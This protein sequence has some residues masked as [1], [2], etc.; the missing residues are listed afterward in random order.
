MTSS[1]RPVTD[2]RSQWAAGEKILPLVYGELRRIAR[3]SMNRQGPAHTLQAAALVH[4]AYMRLI[5]ESGRQWENRA[6][7]FGFA[8]KAMRHVLVDYARAGGAAKRGGQDKPVALEDVF[9][10]SRERMAEVVALDNALRVSAETV[11]RDW[12]AAKAWRYRE[13][14]R[15]G[16]D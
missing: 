10:I 16:A 14:E 15:A 4:K 9:V 3:R 1:G 6:H 12:R 8:A 13:L 2:L 5:G 7:F 11:M